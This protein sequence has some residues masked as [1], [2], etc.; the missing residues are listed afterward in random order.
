MIAKKEIR[1]RG[2]TREW[3]EDRERKLMNYREKEGLDLED[4]E[5]LS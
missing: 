2:K 4:E 1:L 3:L 5:E